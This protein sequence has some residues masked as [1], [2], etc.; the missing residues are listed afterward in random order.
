MAESQIKRSLRDPAHPHR[1]SWSTLCCPSKITIPE[2]AHP[3]AKLVFGEMKRQRI[4]YAELEL[5]SGV[6]TS[7]FKAWRTDNTPG[8]A[9]V[10]ATLRALGWALVPVPKVEHLSPALRSAVEQAASRYGVTDQAMAAAMVAAGA[11]AERAAKD[12]DQ[13]GHRSKSP[14]QSKEIGDFL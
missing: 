2:R 14:N 9:S 5:R 4:S 11:F 12:I 1:V 10:E 8:L 3:L 6:L 13:N 7:T